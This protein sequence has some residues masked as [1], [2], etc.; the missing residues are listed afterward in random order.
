M[1]GLSLIKSVRW[2]EKHLSLL[3]VS[4]SKGS[5]EWRSIL[6][7]SF[8]LFRIFLGTVIS[9]RSVAIGEE[10]SMKTVTITDGGATDY[11]N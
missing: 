4:G 3:K 8:T 7:V 6:G 1:L 9:V 2:I 10:S 5:P 11:V